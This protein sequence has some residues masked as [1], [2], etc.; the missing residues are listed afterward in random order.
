MKRTPHLVVVDDESV[1]RETLEMLLQGSGVVVTG[2][3]SADEA[4]NVLRRGE[5][6]D[7]M[8]SDVVMPGTDG[9]QLFDQARKLRPDLPIVLVT[10]RDSAM[11]WVVQKG[12]VALLKPYSI[13]SLNGVLR[14][15]L[16]VTV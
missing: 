1:H 12:S 13:D 9:L 4:M 2:C 11:E 10:G 5:H 7:L 8:L 3:A 14:E 16:G 15:Y 6:V